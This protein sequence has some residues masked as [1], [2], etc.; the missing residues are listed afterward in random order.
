MESYLK[1]FLIHS[2]SNDIE[3]TLSEEGKQLYNSNIITKISTQTKY[4]HTTFN[5]SFGCRDEKLIELLE[6]YGS[7]RI[8]SNEYNLIKT[9]FYIFYIPNKYS[10][11]YTIVRDFDN[12][13]I[14]KIIINYEKYKIDILKHY[15]GISSESNNPCKS[16]SSIDLSS[17]NLFITR[18]KDRNFLKWWKRKSKKYKTLEMIK[19]YLEIPDEPIRIKE[20]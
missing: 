12:S 19:D 4:F 2:S 5:S 10:N 3:Y 20:V 17:S 14:P 15:L 13:N 8:F 9:R 1:I 16:I 18:T 7:S 6:K 11:Y